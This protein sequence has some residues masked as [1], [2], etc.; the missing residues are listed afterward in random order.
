[1][2]YEVQM[3]LRITGQDGTTIIPTQ[4]EERYYVNQTLKLMA[5]KVDQWFELAAKLEKEK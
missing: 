3:T 4:T 5:S 2:N 1:M